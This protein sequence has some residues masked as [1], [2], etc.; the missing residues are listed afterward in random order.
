MVKAAFFDIDGTLVSFKTHEVSRKSLDSLE[1][2][3]KKGIKVFICSGR[4]KTFMDTLGDFPFDGY[5]CMNGALIYADGE[6][7]YRH[8]LPAG[9]SASI[10]EM[11]Q[12]L[13]VPCAAFCEEHVWI[14]TQNARSIAI[15]D[16]LAITPPPFMDLTKLSNGPIYQFTAFV[17]REDEARLL[18]PLLGGSVTAR[19]HPEFTDIIPGNL[20]K[21]EGIAQV[22]GHYGIAREE[23]IAFGDGG[24]DIEMLEYAG[25]GVAMGNA[26]PEVKAHADHVTLSVDDDGITAALDNMGLL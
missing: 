4:H 21:A 9:D 14:N 26:V 22:L 1:R 16:M 15:S 17:D 20:S 12:R 13:E 5:I 2:L 6:I 25:I 3:Q 19:W 7:I 24:N 18:A 8:P 10:A 11:A 23:T